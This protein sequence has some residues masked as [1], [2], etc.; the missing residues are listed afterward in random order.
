MK[1]IVNGEIVTSATNMREPVRLKR[2]GSANVDEEARLKAES[3]TGAS[4]L[5]SQSN[6]EQKNL[7]DSIASL[8]SSQSDEQRKNNLLKVKKHYVGYL[9]SLDYEVPPDLKSGKT[10]VADEVKQTKRIKFEDLSK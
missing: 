9:E 3:P 5:G 1:L 2:L 10:T 7:Q 8:D 4:G 6:Q